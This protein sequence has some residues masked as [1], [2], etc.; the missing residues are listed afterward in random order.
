MAHSNL[1]L[2]FYAQGRLEAAADSFRTAI[3]ID[4]SLEQA[5]AALTAI[6]AAA[7]N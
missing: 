2:A 1:G 3:R 4:P 7:G 5:K 6:E